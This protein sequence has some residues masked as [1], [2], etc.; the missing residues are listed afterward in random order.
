[1]PARPYRLRQNQ[2]GHIKALLPIMVIFKQHQAV[3][4]LRAGLA[5]GI[6]GALDLLQRST[7]LTPPALMAGPTDRNLKIRCDLRRLACRHGFF[8]EPNRL[9]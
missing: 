9:E 7:I 2:A 1:V 6:C 8:L 4:Q 3:G 5:L